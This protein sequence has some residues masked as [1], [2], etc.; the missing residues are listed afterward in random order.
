MPD[1]EFTAEL[2][3]SLVDTTALPGDYNGDGSVDA[4]DYVV[5]RK[6]LGENVTPYSC[7]DGSG[8]GLVDQDDYSVW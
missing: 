7:A 5:W 1:D 6:S 4:A 2:W 8:N 3:Q